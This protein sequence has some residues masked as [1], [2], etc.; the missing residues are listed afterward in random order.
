[1]WRWFVSLL[2]PQGKL[3][4]HIA[5]RR[6]FLATAAAAAAAAVATVGA[7]PGKIFLVAYTRG[8]GKSTFYQENIFS[9]RAIIIARKIIVIHCCIF[10]RC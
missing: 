10:W 2:Y 4:V 3:S 6:T 8:E 7:I 5:G 9:K 1:M